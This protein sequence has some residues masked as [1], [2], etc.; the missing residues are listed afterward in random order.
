MISSFRRFALAAVAVLALSPTARAAD[1]VVV[2]AGYIPVLGAAQAF[3]IDNLGWDKENGFDLQLKQFDSGPNM[4]QA[5]ASGTLDT[6]IAGVGPVIVARSQGIGVR[7]VAA[8]AVEEL[9]V[10][11]GPDLA[12]QPGSPA[13]AIAALSKK[14]G[15][16]L[17]V[18]TQPAGSVPN[19][20]LQYWLWERAKAD[21]AA[22]ELVPMGIDAT[23]Q[24]LLAGAVDAAI[25]REP[26]L[27]IITDRNPQ[28][29]VLAYGGDILP[30]QPGN[31]IALTDDFAKAHPD[32][33]QKLVD[34]TVKATDLI[35]A[36]PKVAAKAVEAA[37]GKGLISAEVMERALTSKAVKFNVDPAVIAEQ[38]GVMQDY[39]VKLGAVKQASPLEGLFDASYYAKATNK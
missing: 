5:L 12:A 7:V 18:A 39:Q 17:K 15:R 20:M 11:A 34:L 8:T 4:I 10:A 32:I 6:Y 1:P 14:L 30:N 21:K 16:P 22:I 26:A 27:T 36:D 23:Q 37:L 2:R 38:T 33:A 35:K 25:V 3:V 31:V 28:V 19:T 24:A 9:V 29:K 13:E